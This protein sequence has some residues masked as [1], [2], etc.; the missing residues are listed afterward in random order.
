VRPV[1]YLVNTRGGLEGEPGQFYDYILAGNGL[2]VK[3]QNPLLEATVLIAPAEVRGLWPLREE[4]RLSRGKIPRYLHGLAVSVLCADRLQE[5]YVAVTWDDGYHLEVPPQ[6]GRAAGVSYERL[7]GT[8]VDIHS[9]TTMTAFFSTTD[10][11]DEQGMGLFMVVGRLDTLIP[12]VLL[13][14]GLYGYFAPVEIGEVFD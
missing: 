6:E 2:F 3:A 12:E 13:R 4:V 11:Q 8:V 10:N 5:R 9:H 7:P 1:G 14:I